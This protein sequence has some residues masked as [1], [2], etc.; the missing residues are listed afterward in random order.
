MSQTRRRSRAQQTAIG[1]LERAGRVVGLLIVTGVGL[2]AAIAGVA[3]AFQGS[4]IYQVPEGVRPVDIPGGRFVRIASQDKPPVYALHV[5][6]TGDAPT[7]VHFHGNGEQLADTTRALDQ[8]R[9]KGFGLFAVEYPG[10]GQANRQPPTEQ[11]LYSAAETAI[12]YLQAELKVSTEKMVLQGQSLGT[13]VAL[14]MARRGYGSRLIL[15]SPFTSMAD[16]FRDR[17]PF[18]PAESLLHERYDN[19]AKA[20]SIRQPVLIV[21][22]TEDEVVPSKMGVALG[23]ALPSSAVQ[24]VT[25]AGH[26]DL[27]TR[28]TASAGEAELMRDTRRRSASSKDAPAVEHITAFLK[29]GGTRAQ[30]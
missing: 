12:K 11:A 1:A 2:Y 8:L 24:M 19:L 27:F 6:A 3:F 15:I 16:L 22:G 28:V 20:P 17:V 29:G 26:N 9:V 23:H 14:E 5:P 7:L 25:G 13:G 30:L 18:L 21:H 10:Y 4:L